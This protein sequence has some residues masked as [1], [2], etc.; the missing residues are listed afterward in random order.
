MHMSLA[1]TLF[2]VVMCIAGTA[3]FASFVFTFGSG[4]GYSRAAAIFYGI[5]IMARLSSD[6]YLQFLRT[7]NGTLGQYP[8][9]A[10]FIPISL[11]CFGIAAASI[12]WPSI[13]QHLANR[14]GMI[15]FF[16][17][18]PILIFIRGLP[19]YL[20]LHYAFLDLAWILYAVLW[21]R[22]R[23]GYRKVDRDNPGGIPPVL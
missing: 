13:P 3:F 14:F 21:F 5:G 6:A 23:D 12:L 1:Q 7:S 4:K 2:N 19:D 17:I 10:W 9:L 11:F 18:C 8:I 20:Q 15:L 16:I 22:V